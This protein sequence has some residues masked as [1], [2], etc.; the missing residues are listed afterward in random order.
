MRHS[1]FFIFLILLVLI[2]C[3][4]T[5][6]SSPSDFALELSWNTGSLPP[7]YTTSYLMT[8]GPELQGTLE[9]QFGYGDKDEANQYS[10]DFQ[11]T[12]E[13]LEDLYQ[14]LYD[15]DMFRSNW[16]EGEISAGGPG[17]SLILT[18]YGEQYHIPSL[19][20][21]SGEDYT[22]VDAAIETIQGVVPAE[23]WEEMQARQEN[24]EIEYE[25]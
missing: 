20:E 9:Y 13:Q 4:P 21:L 23:L 12:Q 7:E 5:P 11:I 15:E 16:Q 2:S 14:D 6:S 17:S 19:S 1:Y 22:R 25:Y 3:T 10:I 8:I 24:Y 18:A